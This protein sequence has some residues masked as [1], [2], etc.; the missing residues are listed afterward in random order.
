[1]RALCFDRLVD[2]KSR[3]VLGAYGWLSE[4]LELPDRY[5]V[6]IEAEA[7]R[8]FQSKEEARKFY[9]ARIQPLKDRLRSRRSKQSRAEHRRTL[10]VLAGA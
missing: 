9:L 1:M 6:S 8:F 3:K 4:S 2:P 5:W 7:Y 10:T